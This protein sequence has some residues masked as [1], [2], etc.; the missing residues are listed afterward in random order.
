MKTKILTISI[1]LMAFS[2]SKSFSQ[3][4]P[5]RIKTNV[6]GL[7]TL[8]YEN[9]FSNKM[10][11]QVGLQYNPENFPVKNTLVKSIALE[12]RYYFKS[13]TEKG[14]GI[15][16]ATYAKFSGTKEI[17]DSD[18]SAKIKAIATGL[19][20]G[21]LHVFK[22]KMVAEVFAGAGYNVFKKIDTDFSNDFPEKNYKFDIRIGIGFGFSF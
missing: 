17:N 18:N 10:S 7:F 4:K 3:E 22:N 20:L 2:I 15:F 8:F 1:L 14:G 5:N 9:Q 16:G 12:L 13:F 19:N 6:L 11:L 21:Y